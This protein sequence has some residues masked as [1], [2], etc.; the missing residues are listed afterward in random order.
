MPVSSSSSSSPRPSHRRK[1]SHPTSSTHQRGSS[2]NPTNALPNR[3]TSANPP[4][5]RLKVSSPTDQTHD[6]PSPVGSPLP[7]TSPALVDTPGQDDEFVT[8]EKKL[9]HIKELAQDVISL[10]DNEQ[11]WSLV[12]NSK[13]AK[14]K[15]KK[16]QK[17]AKRIHDQPAEFHFDTRGFR[18]GRM[19]SIKV[20]FN[21]IILSNLCALKIDII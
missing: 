3:P 11:A 14:G 10:D 1:H 2:S 19:I 18:N 9:F 8:Q 5:K 16:Q 6:Q 13:S 12:S 15:L 7:E 17:L 20:D 4:L 21:H